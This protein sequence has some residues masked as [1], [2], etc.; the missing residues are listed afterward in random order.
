MYKYDCLGARY[1]PALLV[2]DDMRVR[3][4]R[5]FCSLWRSGQHLLNLQVS[6]CI[7]LWADLK[8]RTRL[9]NAHLLLLLLLREGDGVKMPTFHFL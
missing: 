2:G 8:F 1:S 3:T 7:L 4:I 6:N 5:K 9:P